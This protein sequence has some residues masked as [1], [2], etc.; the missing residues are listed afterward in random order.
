M[1]TTVLP[2]K[3]SCKLSCIIFSFSASSAEVASSKKIKSGF[4]YT[5][6]AIRIRC[7]C[8]PLKSSPAAPILVSNPKGG[9]SSGGGDQTLLNGDNDTVLD[10]TL[11]T[12][13]VTIKN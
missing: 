6:L 5:A 11:D 13:D 2:L 7:F 1:I 3:N 10:K 4:L 9:L 12:L 8:P